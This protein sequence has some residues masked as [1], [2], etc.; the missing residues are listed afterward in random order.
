MSINLW[1][2]I[3]KSKNLGVQD[4][5]GKIYSNLGFSQLLDSGRNNAALNEVMKQVVLMR[6]LDPCSKLR[7]S[8]LLKNYFGKEISYKQILTMMDH[9]AENEE[10]IRT[11]IFE[12][13]L[14]GRKS[15]SLA[16]FDVTTL[17]FEA[18]T[19][20]DLRDFGYCKDGKFGEVQ[21]VLAV[22]SDYDGIPLAYEIF[23]GHTSEVKAFSH[24][25]EGFMVKHGIQSLNVF[26]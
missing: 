13:L 20:D 6:V 21:I 14:Q 26:R 7:S 12:N 25:L 17:Y 5:L 18:I 22:L 8:K 23:P 3:K 15:I 16:L 1:D 2:M 10:E 4:L 11:R 19:S 24:V 9:I